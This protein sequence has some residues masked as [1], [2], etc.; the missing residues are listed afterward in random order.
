[1]LVDE[2][3]GRFESQHA[4]GSVQHHTGP[5]CGGFVLAGGRLFL[6]HVISVIIFRLSRSRIRF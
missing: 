3:E 5:N 2:D 4:S 1:M 6:E